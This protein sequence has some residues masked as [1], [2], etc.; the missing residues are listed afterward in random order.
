MSNRRAGR[1]KKTSKKSSSKAAAGST[2]KAASRATTKKSRAAGPAK[3]TR[4]SAAKAR[5]PRKSVAKVAV[6]KPIVPSLSAV[7]KRAIV[8]RYIA[9]YNARD[10][11]TIIALYDPRARME[12]PVGLPP[13]VGLDAIAALYQ[14][15]FDMGVSI[16]HD[17]A[18]RCAGNEVAFPLL[19]TSP[20]SKLDVID[21]F[22]F[23]RDGKIV[24]MRAYWGPDNLEGELAIRQ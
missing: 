9:A 8:E 17:G 18:V 2:K 19:A 15:G 22:E 7:E 10:T 6:A 12:D 4:K 20:S 16:A 24:R 23:G 3:S 21:V 1:S 13:A 14:M 5:A 11:A